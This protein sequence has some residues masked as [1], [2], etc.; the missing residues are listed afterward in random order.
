MKT[1]PSVL[2]KDKDLPPGPAVAFAL[3]QPASWET[4]CQSNSINQYV[5]IN[6]STVPTFF[7]LLHRTIIFFML[8]T[9]SFTFKIYIWI[10]YL[11]IDGD[12][13][14]RYEQ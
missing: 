7:N 14:M 8:F 2:T 9:V 5:K 11:F 10:R 6:D 12:F 1:P 4:Q 13:L 3:G